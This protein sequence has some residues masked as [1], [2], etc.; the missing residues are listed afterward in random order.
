M[1]IV[2]CIF[3]FW[4]TPVRMRP[5]IDTFPV[6]GHFLSMYVPS[7]ACQEHTNSIEVKNLATSNTNP[8]SNKNLFVISGFCHNVHK[9]SALLWY[10]VAYCGNSLLMFCDNTSVPKHQYGITITCWISQKSTDLN[11]MLL[12]EN[13]ILIMV[14]SRPS[15][16]FIILTAWVLI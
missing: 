2:R 11:K 10:Y 1:T 15:Y 5:L 13:Y 6:N 7:I 3:I 14:I 4:T 8:S 16:I 12:S 9:I